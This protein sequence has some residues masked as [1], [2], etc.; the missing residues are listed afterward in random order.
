[1]TQKDYLEDLFPTGKLLPH[2]KNEKGTVLLPLR[3]GTWL[4]LEQDSLTARERYLL[5][6]LAEDSESLSDNPWSY[7]LHEKGML[8]HAIDNLQAVHVH[9]W[10]EL[11]LDT[12]G[13]ESWLDMMTALLPNQFTVFQLTSKDYVFLLEQR[14]L[15]DVGDV[16]ADTLSAMEIDFGLRLTVFLGQLWPKHVIAHWPQLFQAERELFAQ[17]LEKNSQI[18]LLTFSQ[19]Y[20]WSGQTHVLLDSSL[21]SLLDHQQLEEV[22][23]ALWQAG[24]VLT[25][26]A[27]TLYIHRNTLQYRLEKWYDWT[28]LQL[29]DL[30]DLTLCYTILLRHS[31]FRS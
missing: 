1:M 11:D 20:L 19:L 30:T 25:K 29:K 4:S 24:A 7:F 13:R 15:L 12:D 22:I 5:Q 6:C 21:Q 26:A 17:W 31:L 18:C 3:D 8:P 28:G 14:P 9:I 23:I 27:Q 16:L 2:K 10:S